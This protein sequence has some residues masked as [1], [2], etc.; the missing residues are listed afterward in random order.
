[1]QFLNDNDIHILALAGSFREGSLNQALIRAA[2]ELA[3]D[4]V[5]IDDLD[6]S[7]SFISRIGYQKN[8]AKRARNWIRASRACS[9]GRFERRM[10][11]GRPR[12]AALRTPG[13][14]SAGFRWLRWSAHGC[15]KRRETSEDAGRG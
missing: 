10:T 2:R 15:Q 6:L 12:A 14:P 11:F 9:G 5:H 13:R 3:P 4:H 8:C 7:L 1:M